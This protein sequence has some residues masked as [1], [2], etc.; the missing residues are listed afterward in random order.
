MTEKRTTFTAPDVVMAWAEAHAQGAPID[1]V[2]K[3][4]DRFLALAGVVPVGSAVAPGRPAAYST[5]ELVGHERAALGL[6][7]RGRHVTTPVV[8]TASIAT[9]AVEQAGT[10]GREQ[11]AM[12]RTVAS[13]RDRVVCVVG[14]AGSGKT[15]ALAATAEAFRRDGFVVIGAA[16]SG[17]AARTL[18]E[19]TGIPSGTLRRVL[20]EANRRGGLPPRCVVVVDEAGMADTRT[21]TRLLGHVEHCDGKAILVGDPAQLG[22]VGAGGLFS[23]IVDRVGAVEL[24][25]NHRQRDQLEQRALA[26]LRDGDSSALL[27]QAAEGGRLVVAEDAM[28]AKACLVAGWWCSARNDLAGSVMIAHRRRDVDDL[29][30]AARALMI[31]DARLGP[32]RLP[33]PSGVE[34]AIG[35]R[36]ICIR[37]DHHVGVVNGTRG[38]ITNADPAQGTAT[39]E[40]NDGRRI[41]LPAA[42]L[43][44]GHV[45]HAYALTGHKTQGVTVE[46]TFVLAP[47][48]GRLKEWGYVA[49]SRARCETR[50]YTTQAQ[51]EP[52]TP[53]A[54]Q[55]D[56]PDPVDRLAAALT[57]PATD[58]LAIDTQ[59]VPQRGHRVAGEVRALVAQHE[60][61]D[62]ERGRVQRDEQAARREL[63][64]I[65]MLARARHG[66][67]LR[68]QIADHQRTRTRLTAELRR[69][70]RQLHI[71][72]QPSVREVRTPVSRRRRER[73]QEPTPQRGLGIEL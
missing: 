36:V 64:G 67:R 2:L 31:A 38:T 20:S 53:P 45:S 71:L 17:V 23:A 65:G 35:D 50:V 61:L 58:T 1:R 5:R 41:A 19:E 40:T 16:P 25:D 68:G 12:V 42:Y 34:L 6:V 7:D 56:R 59:G 15:T 27:T 47:G 54:H 60:A 18:A 52:D 29:N 32:E 46:R 4:A 11:V 3:E 10:L 69:I 39:L 33:L 8:S 51:L 24:S 43:D 49:L 26:A 14:R 9:V 21:L 63:A 22:A 57:R 62:S 70:D 55:P 30:A 72:G 48:E 66:P 73:L 13:N 28:E 37:N 44:A